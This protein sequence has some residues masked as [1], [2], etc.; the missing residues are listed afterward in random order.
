MYHMYLFLKNGDNNIVNDKTW[1]TKKFIPF[2]IAILIDIFLTCIPYTLDLHF[3]KF[4]DYIINCKQCSLLYTTQHC[5][6]N[7]QFQNGNFM[8]WI[9]IK[10]CY[11]NLQIYNT[12]IILRYKV[13]VYRV[14]L[15]YFR[16]EKCYFQIASRIT[17]SEKVHFSDTL[18]TNRQF[19]RICIT[20]V[21]MRVLW[22][23]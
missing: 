13:R 2:L 12:Y 18:Y 6:W 4:S 21:S 1:T 15:L 22:Y 7:D 8:K 16:N 14:Y 5:I 17:P 11:R 9:L 19:N 10:K 23:L 3:K 20:R